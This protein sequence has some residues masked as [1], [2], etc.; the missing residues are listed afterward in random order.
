[1]GMQDKEVF[2]RVLGLVEPWR[3]KEVRLDLE[4]GRVNVEVE[5]RAGEEWASQDGRRLHIHSRELRRWRHLDTMQLTT[6]IECLVP[7][8]VVPRVVDPQNGRTTMVEVPWA[9]G[10]RSRWTAMFEAW[11]VRVLEAVPTL[12]RACDLLDI[13]WHAAQAIKARAVQ[14]GLERRAEEEADIGHIGIDEKSFG[15]GQDYISCAVDIDGRRVL[16]VVEGRTQEAAGELIR[17]ALPDEEDRGRVKA[18]CIDMWAA[19]EAA[20][21]QELPAASVVFDPFHVVAHAGKAVNEVRRGEHKRLAAQGEDV[22][23]G[24]RQLWL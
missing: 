16:E 19:F 4:A 3:V 23:K 6:V 2:S 18:A 20:V 7:G 8:V 9:A 13:D 24:T 21:G 5:C 10:P 17:K 14:R 15:R 1:M 11:A 22:L 12:S